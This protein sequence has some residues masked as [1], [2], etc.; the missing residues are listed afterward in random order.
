MNRKWKRKFLAPLRAAAALGAAALAVSGCP[1]QQTDA[2]GYYF[3]GRG[4]Y[5]YVEDSGTPE[6]EGAGTL[7]PL[8]LINGVGLNQSSWD[9][10]Q[11]DLA[12][13]VR[14]I[15]YDRGGVGLSEPGRNPRTGQVIAEELDFL[16]AGIDARPPYVLTAHSLGGMF[17]RIYA[18]M[19]PEKVA[20]IL[21]L[22]TAH[23]DLNN[24]FAEL[25]SPEAVLSYQIQQG[26]VLIYSS[27]ETGSLGEYV[28][29]ENTAAMVRANRELPD[30]P[31]I[32][33]GRDSSQFSF[34]ESQDEIDLAYQ[35]TV[36]LAQ[37][38]VDL[39]PHGEYRE[40]AGSTHL[41]QEDSP[42]SIIQAVRDLYARIGFDL[43]SEE[44]L[45]GE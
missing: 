31:L 16:L 2:D 20:A 35:L 33:I 44:K 17:L 41:V 4:Y 36:E 42:E 25:L 13:L 11:P 29:F 15:S 39:V 43:P 10:I 19:F 14:V 1:D 18:N 34:I 7:P 38:Q 28:N 45:Q 5:L 23:E 30:V 37:E 40:I 27:R 3:N 8:V 22:D 24:K 26:L 21:L 12:K 32:Y 9:A 6:R